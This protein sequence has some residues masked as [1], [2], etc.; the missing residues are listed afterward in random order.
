[1]SKRNLKKL[2]K[3]NEALKEQCAQQAT[4]SATPILDALME[5]ENYLKRHYDFRFNRLIETTE[6]R[7]RGTRKYVLLSP[8]HFNSICMAVRKAGINCWDK[9]V[10]RFVFSSQ[11][12]EYHPFQLY[13]QELPL[14][15]GTDRLKELA[16]RV[17]EDE[18]WIRSFHR[19]MLAMTA[20]WMGMDETHA[21][22]VAPILVSH[23]QG[24]NKSTFIKSLLPAELQN[25]YTDDFTLNSKGQSVRKLSEYGLVCMDEFD[26]ETTSRMPQLKNLMQMASLNFI[27]SYQKN[28]CHLPRIASFAGTSNRKDLLTDPS[29]SRRFICIE[30]EKKINV[31]NIDH[32][33]IYAQLKAELSQGE[34]YWFDSSEESEIQENNRSFYRQSVEEEMFYSCFRCALSDEECME[35]SAAD[36]FEYIKK[37]YPALMRK[38]SAASFGRTLVALGVEKVHTRVGNKYL[39]V[40]VE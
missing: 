38:A 16:G 7:V 12:A 9:D 2:R 33:Q 3:E 25:Y 19:W 6:Y 5:M 37:K 40:K 20:Q 8:R 35:L 27:K 39:V 22:S 15:D 24:R 13:M 32:Q 23:T 26:K 1:M 10:N 18:Y 34:R 36:I 21:N 14:W 28:F 17:S 30:V 31:D 29:G 4:P 11:T